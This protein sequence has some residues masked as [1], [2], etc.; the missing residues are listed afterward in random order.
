M[1][2]FYAQ[3]VMVARNNEICVTL[4]RTFKE[5]IVGGIFGDDAHRSRWFDPDGA[6]R[7]HEKKSAFFNLPFSET[8][9]CQ[10]LEIFP[11]DWFADE[12]IEAAILP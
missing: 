8:E 7:F 6:G 2:T 10:N 5:P 12:E 9:P 1:E 4:N 11:D 3:Q